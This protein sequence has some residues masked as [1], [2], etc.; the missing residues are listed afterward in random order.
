MK[1]DLSIFIDRYINELRDSSAAVFIGAG[2]SKST[3]YVDWKNL[4]RDIAQELGLNVDKEYD[5]VSLAQYCYNK[6]GNRSAINDVIFKEFSQEKEPSENHKILA[7]L[8]IFTYW[9]TNYDSLIEDALRDVQRVVDVKRNNKQLSITRPHRDAIV[10]KMHGDK[11]DP[12]D[13]IIIK[14]DYEK[15]HRE[16]AQ[17]I[18]TLSGDLISKTFLFIGLSFSDPNIDYILS[19]VRIDYGE[20]NRRQ[21]YALMRNI[22]EKD[23]EEK[24]DYEYA[25]RK[26]ELFIED[27]KRYNIKALMIDDYGEIIKVLYEIERRLNY[28]NVFISGSAADYGSF[29]KDEALELIHKLSNSLI[30]VD[31]KLISGFGLGVGSAV[32]TGA[33]EEIYLKRKTINDDRLL[34]RPFP[35]GIQNEENRKKLWTTYRKDMISRAGISIF[36]FGNKFDN[37]SQNV[38]LAD[39]VKEEYEIACQYGNLIVPIG[40]TGFVA[41]EIWKEIESNMMNFYRNVDEELT[42]AFQLLNIKSDCEAIIK[43]VMHFIDLLRRK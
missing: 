42:R 4:L 24:A 29:T 5:L 8:P 33:L 11:D 40:C 20:G 34:L 19:R 25:K 30:R 18:T 6:N 22:L 27:L 3:G 15:Y 37:T 32:I 39:G 28:N 26:H 43:N 2:F 16:H 38:I 13:T 1:G 41:E 31:Y 17:F 7:R 9:T 23:Y 21:H 10:Y 12:D 14:D 36:L 35:Q